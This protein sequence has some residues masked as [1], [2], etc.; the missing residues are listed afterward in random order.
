M[1]WILEVQSTP[2]SRLA[3]VQQNM[4]AYLEDV[5]ALLGRILAAVDTK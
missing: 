4:G 2:G 5:T 1:V 3:E